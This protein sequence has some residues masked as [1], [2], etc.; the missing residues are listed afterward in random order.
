[1]GLA[2]V[3]AQ[4][5]RHRRGE[6]LLDRRI[7]SM[8][9]QIGLAED[10]LVA[11]AVGASAREKLKGILA[12]LA[13]QKHP[14]GQCMRDLAKHRPEMSKQSRERICGRLK[15]MVKGTGR[16]KALSNDTPGA[17]MLIDDDVFA[18]LARVDDEALEALVK[19]AK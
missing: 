17:C 2:L 12:R 15:S 7:D 9:D 4:A 5:E 3:D 14:F 19:E 1:M 13:K 11:L 6:E 8:L 16:A 18:L 10:D